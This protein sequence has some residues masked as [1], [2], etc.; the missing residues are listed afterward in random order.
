MSRIRIRHFALCVSLAA[1]LCAALPASALAA[2]TTAELVQRAADRGQ[3]SE[4]KRLIY[5][6]RSY[7][8]P[9]LVPR[10]LRGARNRAGREVTP[11]L[12]GADRARSGLSD[13][14]RLEL[15]R[16]LARP[17]DDPTDGGYCENWTAL[18][19][20]TLVT[21]S[22]N[23]KVHW[24]S[25]TVDAPAST[26]TTPANGIPDY[27]E[28]VATVLEEVY[29]TEVS[30]LGWNSPPIDDVANPESDV[31]I[32][33]LRD[34][35]VYGY[36]APE[37]TVD[38][39]ATS[40]M[41][42][43]NDFAS[44]SSLPDDAL[45]V[46]AAHEFHHMIQYGY[47]YLQ[48]LWMLESTATWIEDQVYN[49]IDDYLNYLPNWADN[50][51]SPLT[52]SG[53]SREYGSAVWNHWL[54]DVEPLAADVVRR[55][56]E[57]SDLAEN[58]V[59]GGGFAPAAYSDAI[60]DNSN[61]ASFSESFG[62][63]A[64]ALAEWKLEVPLRFPDGANYPEVTR[65]GAMAIGQTATL[66]VDHT[67]FKL[68]DV[69]VPSTGPIRFR[70]AS[71][72]ITTPLASSL[73]ALVARKPSGEVTSVMAV[74]PSSGYATVTLPGANQFAR[75][76]AVIVNRD[77]AQTGWGVGDWAWDNDAVPFALRI[78]EGNL[79]PAATFSLGGEAL[80]GAPTTFT[81]AS[82]DP[83]PGDTLSHSWDLD[84]DGQFDD[85]TG[86]TATY[87]YLLTG[88][89]TARLRT[90]DEF[91]ASGEYSLVFP[92]RTKALA[93]DPSGTDQPPVVRANL[94]RL[95]RVKK[96]RMRLRFSASEAVRLTGVIKYGR[97]QIA[98]AS[99][100]GDS[101]KK[102]VISFKIKKKYWKLLSKRK[103]LKVTVTLTALDSTNQKFSD[104]RKTV[105]RKG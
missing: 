32:C 11:L 102:G 47:D 42:L 74:V 58:T 78:D 75:I 25:S 68:V 96:G 20:S 98:K 66:P 103:K 27:V 50:P 85:A 5:G 65:A 104:K 72:D 37:A 41:V 21:G 35:N 76:T 77:V 99:A 6:L 16:Y 52:K 87:T 62:R 29:T 18:P 89:Q 97:R 92:V 101:T 59:A 17:V 13:A 26:D 82:T 48:D 49:S 54:S 33:Q 14:Q 95:P 3:I 61:G 38:R 46:T 53:L 83:N 31:Y 100:K 45:K 71:N 34:N 43:D 19:V 7:A 70:A 80:V 90:V 1:S 15:D 55:A 63:F 23:F 69:A 4:A 73:A 22:G 12:L 28:R 56:W 30:T 9:S 8:N 57:K 39:S 84:N 10:S 24:I 64:L 88:E 91:G 105:L 81:A 67:A 93:E 40:Y 79:P 94:A 44:Y 36:V 2:K 60:D 51:H 86:S